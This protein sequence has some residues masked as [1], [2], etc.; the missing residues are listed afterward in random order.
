MFLIGD[1]ANDDF[2]FQ[3]NLQCV[4]FFNCSQEICT[5]RCLSRGAAGSGR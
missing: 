2:N 5:A 4:L 1:R 3:V